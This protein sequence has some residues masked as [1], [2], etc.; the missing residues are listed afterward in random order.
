[1]ILSRVAAEGAPKTIAAVGHSSKVTLKMRPK[2]DAKSTSEVTA[3]A[4]LQP[5]PQVDDDKSS[6]SKRSVARK[7]KAKHVNAEVDNAEVRHSPHLC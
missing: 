5:A 6:K 3:K 4:K 7:P 2:K 1:M